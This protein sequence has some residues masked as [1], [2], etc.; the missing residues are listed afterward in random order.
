MSRKQQNKIQDYESLR[1][2]VLENSFIK[3]QNDF[4]TKHSLKYIKIHN[5]S[6]TE[7]Y[8]I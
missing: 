6:V 3:S 7:D 5:F 1:I 2:I 8:L 4:T